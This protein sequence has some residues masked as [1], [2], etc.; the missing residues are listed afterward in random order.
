MYRC[1]NDNSRFL[2]N[3]ISVIG[4]QIKLFFKEKGIVVVENI[5]ELKIKLV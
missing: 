4:F 2:K 3:A 5:I 1:K